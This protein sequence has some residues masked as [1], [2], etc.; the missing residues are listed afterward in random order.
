MRHLNIP[1][2]H[3]T[4]PAVPP[5]SLLARVELLE[6]AMGTVLQLQVSHMLAQFEAPVLLTNDSLC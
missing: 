5:K 1:T 2:Q 4:L 3:K 6:A